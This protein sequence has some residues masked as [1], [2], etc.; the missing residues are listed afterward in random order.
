MAA[1]DQAETDVPR[2]PR[3]PWG[4]IAAVVAGLANTTFAAALLRFWGTTYLSGYADGLGL[5]ADLLDYPD[6]AVFYASSAAISL[7]LLF[8]IQASL[9]ALLVALAWYALRGW[10]RKREQA[11]RAQAGAAASDPHPAVGTVAEAVVTPAPGTGPTASDEQLLTI[12]VS[13]VLGLFLTIVVAV[14]LTSQTLTQGQRDGKQ[15]ARR[16]RVIVARDSI[17]LTAGARDSGRQIARSD[18]VAYCAR[19][20]D[21][22]VLRIRDSLAVAPRDQLKVIVFAK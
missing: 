7:A 2:K 11:R 12:I 9:P 16:C 22:V 20:G 1:T 19:F 15:A 5:P 21:R 18:T 8:I 14:A 10:Q 13:A 17:H 6:P 4:T 3:A